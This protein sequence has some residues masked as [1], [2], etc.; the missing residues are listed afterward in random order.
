MTSTP[1]VV[2]Q[3]TW[4]AARDEL[5]IREKA[6]TRQGDAIA[7]AGQPARARRGPRSVLVLAHRRR[8]CPHR[9]T[10]RPARAAVDPAGRDRRGRPR[11]GRLSLTL[12][13]RARRPDD[14]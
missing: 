7:A 5:L 11:P 10:G 12:S 1:P 2:D 8:R 6:H 4:Q 13:G 9:W 3:A 14:R